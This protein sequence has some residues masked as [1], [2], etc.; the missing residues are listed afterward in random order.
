MEVIVSKLIVIIC[1][2]DKRDNID[3]SNKYN[4]YKDR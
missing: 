3:T 2:T 4:D 1:Y